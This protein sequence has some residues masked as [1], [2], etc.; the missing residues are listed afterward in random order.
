MNSK[1]LA[2]KTKKFYC[3]LNPFN[4]ERAQAALVDSL[5]FTAIVAAICTALFYF[6]INYGTASESL[7]NSFYYSDFAMDS[8]KVITYINVLRDG[9]PII[10]DFADY[11][12]SYPEYDYLLALIKEDYSKNSADKKISVQTK[13][14]IAN[15]VRSVLCPFE[16]STDFIFFILK[17]S[18]TQV[19]SRFLVLVLATR[20]RTTDPIPNQEPSCVSFEDEQGVMQRECF[21]VKRVFYSCEPSLS[22]VLEKKIFP[23]VGKVDSAFGKIT[24]GES[25]SLTPFVLG[26]STWIS[27]DIKAI[28]EIESDT[29]F[30]CTEL[31][32]KEPS[33]KQK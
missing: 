32:V 26:L 30:N 29:E 24:L 1:Q 11:T 21:Y 15:T 13:T 6:V 17:E 12:G 20:Q 28:R 25:G 10:L 5:F 3:P 9:T 7:L 18:A 33:C 27:K 16:D 14:A 22:T 4:C 19:E 23:V 2:R 8:L 31:P